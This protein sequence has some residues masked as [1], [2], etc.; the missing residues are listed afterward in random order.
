MK[1]WLIGLELMNFSFV[2]LAQ[3]VSHNR[4]RMHSFRLT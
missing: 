2:Q 1:L 4:F 3:V